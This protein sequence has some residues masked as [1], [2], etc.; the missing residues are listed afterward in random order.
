MNNLENDKILEHIEK[1]NEIV[2]VG[3]GKYGVELLALLAEKGKK[4]VAFYD[5]AKENQGKYMYGIP[6][7]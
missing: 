3:A 6:I 1:K 7:Q 2:L 5:N 4:V